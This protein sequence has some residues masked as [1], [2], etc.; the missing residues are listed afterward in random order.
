MTPPA[1]SGST[2]SRAPG[3]ERV[4]RTYGTAWRSRNAAV[5]SASRTVMLKPIQPGPSALMRLK[6]ASAELL[7]ASGDQKLDAVL[8][9]IELRVA[10][11]IAKLT[12]R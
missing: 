8:A 6:S 1:C 12:P 2:H 3:P 9:E 11:E 10:V 7:D 4:P 5:E